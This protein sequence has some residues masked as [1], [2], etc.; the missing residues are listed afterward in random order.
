MPHAQLIADAIA[1]ID[2]PDT[3]PAPT[4][5]YHALE[6]RERALEV[7]ADAIALGAVRGVIAMLPGGPGAHHANEST[8]ALVY[9][10]DVAPELADA[11]ELPSAREAHDMLNRALLAR[12]EQCRTIWQTIQRRGTANMY[13]RL[14]SALAGWHPGPEQLAGSLR[15]AGIR[16]HATYSVDQLRTLCHITPTL[17]PERDDLFRLALRAGFTAAGERA[18]P[19]I[20]QAVRAF[21]RSLVGGFGTDCRVR[22][23]APLDRLVAAGV[24]VED[25]DRFAPPQFSLRVRGPRRA[26]RSF[27]DVEDA[28][29]LEV[30]MDDA[31]LTPDELRALQRTSTGGLVCEVRPGRLVGMDWSERRRVEQMVVETRTRFRTSTLIAGDDVVAQTPVATPER[32]VRV[33]RERL[34]RTPALPTTARELFEHQ[35]IAAQWI[36]ARFEAGVGCLLADDKGLGKSTTALTAIA[37]QQGPHL[38]VCEPNVVDQWIEEA[39]ATI[40]DWPVY[41]DHGRDAGMEALN[42]LP[43]AARRRAI[44]IT[45]YGRLRAENAAGAAIRAHEWGAVVLDEAQRIKTPSTD[46]SQ[47]ARALRSRMRLALTGSPVE[48]SVLD[49]WSILDWCNP[50]FLGALDRFR[51]HVARS[52]EAAPNGARARRLQAVIA[53]VM[54]RREKD[55]PQVADFFPEKRELPVIEVA[56]SPRQRRLTEEIAGRGIAAATRHAEGTLERG[57]EVLAMIQRLKQVCCHPAIVDGGEW[58]AGASPKF[59]AII[60]MAAAKLAE[61]RPTLI[62]TQMMPMV[63]ALRGAAEARDLPVRHYDGRMAPRSR[64]RREAVQWFQ[65]EEEA[66]LLVVSLR[67]GGTGLNLDRTRCVIHA[68]RWWNPAVED[69][70]TDRGHRLTSTGDLEV[71]HFR[72]ADSIEERIEEIITAKRQL[73]GALVVATSANQ[74]AR[75][76]DTEIADLAGV[77]LARSQAPTRTRRR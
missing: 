46:Q 10:P 11:L 7:A 14:V 35:V 52:C 70:A 53:T 77:A 23:T 16:L 2:G 54:L 57:Q 50:G 34:D 75:L 68:D 42:A 27:T 48:N 76:S 47:A 65:S 5:P 39:R 59:D 72:T 12:S 64:A 9:D 28:Y 3:T 17:T 66:R 43:P 4:R 20:R 44:C 6:V 73:R 55:D 8:L 36:I 61:G 74:L 63:D 51:Q 60:D 56:M 33:W 58:T 18:R 67:A 26:P 24:S 40:P 15:D 69:Q 19:Q 45:S 32:L 13:Q 37:S 29:G 41:V 25:A 30:A 21:A 71:V 22:D 1:R 49:T 31:P 38:V 62:F